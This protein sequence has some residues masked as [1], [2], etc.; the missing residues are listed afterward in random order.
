M[1][2]NKINYNYNYNPSQAHKTPAFKAQMP[3][4]FYV[5][6][7]KNSIKLEFAS[8]K[9]L[10]SITTL[11]SKAYPKILQIFNKTKANA[12][13]QSQKMINN[14][15]TI[16]ESTPEYMGAT[17]IISR[18]LSA[19]QEVEINIEDGELQD[20]ADSNEACIF[21][22]N[23]DKQKMDSKMVNFFNA[24]LSREY[25]LKG[26][27]KDCPRPKIILNK[28]IIESMNPETKQLAKTWGAVG[29][30][31]SIHCVNHVFNGRITAG[32]VNDLIKDKVNL[33]I[34]PEGRMCA[35]KNMN[36]DWKFQGGISDIIK[37]TAKKKDRVKVVPLGFA[38]NKDISSIHIGKPLYF[39]KDNDKILFTSGTVDE[40]LSNNA[41][42]EYLDEIPADSEGYRPILEKGEQVPYRK[43]R[44]YIS[45]I[46]CD[47][48]VV[49]K[50]MAAKSIKD[51][52]SDTDDSV[53]HVIEDLI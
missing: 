52:G 1:N 32:L 41:Y 17:Y 21:I 4:K 50:K 19:G 8:R 9:L 44:D 20:I 40:E 15:T 36:P 47:N 29:V 31:A 38:Y 30:D 2:I 23:H 43:S 11:Y 18:M 27:S 12:V 35:F 42:R 28:D 7:E 10:N 48:L 51:A 22:M 53:L 3:E 25:I 49:C 14:L 16:N 45:G 34:F 5:F 33:F 26:K 6:A 39:K 37:A 46:L 13:I 24:L